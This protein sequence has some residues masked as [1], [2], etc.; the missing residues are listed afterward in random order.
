MQTSKKTYNYNY[1]Y[2]YNLGPILK[3][4]DNTNNFYLYNKSIAEPILKS[5]NNIPNIET[6]LKT[7]D[8]LNTGPILRLYNEVSKTGD[9]PFLHYF[10]YPNESYDNYITNL[11]NLKDYYLHKK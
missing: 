10:P 3:Y 1:N 7:D 4:Y 5:Y 8:M 6:K 2:N 11:Y 9:D